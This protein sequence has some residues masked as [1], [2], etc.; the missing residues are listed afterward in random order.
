MVPVSVRAS[1]DFDSSN[2]VSTITANLGTRHAD[3]EQRIETI[4]ISTRA[5][6]ALLEGL[7]SVQASLYA[8]LAHSPMLLAGLLGVGDRF[9]AFSTIISN[10]PGPREKQYWNGAP[11]LGTYPASAVF[12]GFALNITLISYKDQLDFGIIAC[13]RSLPQVQRMID[14]MEEALVELE[15]MVAA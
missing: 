15:A 14:Y 2:S 12:H 5:G 10:V 3:P 9:P 8:G 11:L 1:E 6:K 13:R 4:M 7:S